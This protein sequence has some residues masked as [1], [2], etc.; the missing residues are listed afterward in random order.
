[1]APEILKSSNNITCAADIFSLGMTILELATD[2]DLPRGGETWHQLRNGQIPVNLVSS[3]SRDLV[4]I[5]M[6]MIE[7]DHLKR[8][9]V[10]DLL[11]FP[12]IRHLM[13]RRKRHYV[14]DNV[15][16]LTSMLAYFIVSTVN[17]ILQPFIRIIRFVRNTVRGDADGSKDSRDALIPAADALVT[18]NRQHLLI[19]GSLEKPFKD[20]VQN[21]NNNNNNSKTDETNSSLDKKNT[22]TPKKEEF[23]NNLPLNILN[24]N[25]DDDDDDDIDRSKPSE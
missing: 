20:V 15:Y 18:N 8:A 3:L 7:P 19:N 25:E 2:L 21:N 10:D 12:R 14:V 1:M 4:A 17:S 6:R 9:T 24:V 16:K 11:D 22:S 13:R 5:I 23:I